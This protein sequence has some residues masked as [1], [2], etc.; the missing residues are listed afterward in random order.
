[1]STGSIHVGRAS[2]D[3]GA[4]RLVGHRDLIVLA[5]LL[6]AFEE[7][8]ALVE[9]HSPGASLAALLPAQPMHSYEETQLLHA[10]L[11]R[12][13]AVVVQCS[14]RRSLQ[15]VLEQVRS[16]RPMPLVI[17]PGGG[18]QPVPFVEAV[19]ADLAEADPDLTYRP[20]ATLGGVLAA[21]RVALL[22]TPETD[23]HAEAL[24]LRVAEQFDSSFDPLR[25]VE[26]E[27]EL[28]RAASSALADARARLARAQ[29]RTDAIERSRTWRLT[30]PFRRLARHRAG[31]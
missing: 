2:G 1:M 6:A 17:L 25:A 24:L 26:R 14:G 4:T 22:T 31:S 20:V 9:I 18:A 11:D 19:V 8:P 10:G 5:A 28:V 30:A 13:D 3:E 7:P 21:S 29:A 23:A 15:A 12:A 16:W 27:Q